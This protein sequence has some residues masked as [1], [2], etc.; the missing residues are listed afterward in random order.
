MEH[1]SE[2]INRM[3]ESTTFA[4]ARLTKELQEQGVDIIKLT[5]GEPDFETP[6]HIKDAAKKAID[7]GETFYTPVQGNSDLITAVINKFK[8]ENNIQYDKN[9]ILVSNGAKHTITNIFMT[10]IDEGD[11]IIIPVPY[12]GT[13]KEIVNLAHGTQVFVEGHFDN[14]YK[15]TAKQLRDKITDKTRAIFIN[16]PSNPTGATYTKKEMKEIAD[17]V[18]QNPNILL[19]SDEIYEHLNF[20]E[21]HESFAQ[22]DY[23]KDQLILVNG[24]SKAYAMTGWRI[25][26]MAAP[27]WITKACKKL[28]GQTTSGASSISQ[29]AAVAALNTKSELYKERIDILRKRRD[30]VVAE[31]KKIPELKF[32][33]PSA[34]FYI[35]SDFSAYYG[36]FFENKQI[37][38]SKEMSMYL[39]KE[40]KVGLVAGSGFG[41]DKCLR[42][43]FT[44]DIEIIKEA[45]VRMKNAL[46]N[47]KK[48]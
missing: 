24:V 17:I 18:K 19:V 27:E 3:E 16:S 40:A 1:L 34:T 42:L 48:Q 14:Q 4:M 35:F 9:Q 25:G 44:V 33:I 7:D 15:I 12:W 39:L 30:F 23:I 10:I 28:Q 13:Y 45:L 41:V 47:L 38:T 37:N 5:L 6:Q 26:Y 21:K 29:K 32:N 20:D 11:E 22:F 31:M 8:N 43:S 36:R 2:R 46:D